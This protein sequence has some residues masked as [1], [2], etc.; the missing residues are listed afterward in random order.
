M[1]IAASNLRAAS[2]GSQPGKKGC[3]AYVA[4]TSATMAWAVGRMTI[5]FTYNNNHVNKSGSG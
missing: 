5:R 1:H 2:G 3:R 4:N